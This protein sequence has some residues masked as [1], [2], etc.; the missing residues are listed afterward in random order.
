MQFPCPTGK[1]P[2]HITYVC[3]S[4]TAAQTAVAL[5]IEIIPHSQT[6]DPGMGTR[7]HL[8]S[9]QHCTAVK[10][11]TF[12]ITTEALSVILTFLPLRIVMWLAS[13]LI[14]VVGWLQLLDIWKPSIPFIR[15]LDIWKPSIPFIK[16]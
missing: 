14:R 15:M 1:L 6:T 10:P 5:K 7:L 13:D 12:A 4:T 3:L 9:A 8:A 2:F 11:Y 16:Q